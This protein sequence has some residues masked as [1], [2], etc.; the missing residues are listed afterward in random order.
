LYIV[1]YGTECYC[2]VQYSTDDRTIM[3][4]KLGYRHT[5][6]TRLRI[7]GEN[8]E[9][10]SDSQSGMWSSHIT[11]N[12]FEG[13]SLYCTSYFWANFSVDLVRWSPVDNKL[14]SRILG[15]R[16]HRLPR[17]RETTLFYPLYGRLYTV[18]FPLK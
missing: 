6:S 12:N 4:R 16:N 13:I 8:R 3:W 9:F 7:L 18:R 10:G 15:L 17:H 2:T 1:Q 5:R 14:N 11:K